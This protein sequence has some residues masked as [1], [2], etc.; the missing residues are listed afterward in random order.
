MDKPIDLAYINYGLPDDVWQT[1]QEWQERH[2]QAHPVCEICRSR[3]SVRITPVGSM[4]A[5][6]LECIEGIRK[7]I[8]DEINWSSENE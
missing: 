1:L 3:A 5:A 2:L 8:E 6:C 4:R 7:Q